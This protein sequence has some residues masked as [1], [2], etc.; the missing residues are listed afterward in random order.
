MQTFPNISGLQRELAAVK[1]NQKIA[2][3]PTMGNL[4]EGH[5]ALVRK[6]RE[7]ADVVVVSIF[8]NPLQ[9]GPNDDLDKYPRTL[10][11]DQQKLEAE[12]VDLLFT[13]TTESIYPKGIENHSLVS[14]PKL[15]D[16]HCGASRP[17]HFDGVTTVVNILLNIIQADIAVFGEKD[18]QQLAII[19]KMTEDLYMPTE[20]IGCPTGRASDGLALSSRNQ[21]LTENEREIAP[22]LYQTLLQAQGQLLNNDDIVTITNKASENLD[23]S[24]FG[25][26]YFNIADAQTLGQVLESSEKVVILV[27]AKLGQTRLIDNVSF[28]LNR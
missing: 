16:Y 3:V 26:D 18:F 20:I 1:A 4:H 15:G 24:G 22:K 28:S 5:L 13:P 7:L 27:A 6:A 14:V 11:I 19:R 25:V 23:K 9:F 8:V 2:F 10:K 12:G 17:G 21:Y